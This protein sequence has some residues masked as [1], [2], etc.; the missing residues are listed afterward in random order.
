MKYVM[1]SAAEAEI[2]AL[3]LK[4]KEMVPVR[5][6]LTKI[7]WH[8]PPSP[9]QCDNSTAVRMTDSTLVPRKYKSW[10]LRLNWLQC[11]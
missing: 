4:A 2:G 7:G 9:I 11:I 6:T 3:L 8:Q 10:D 5:H 1:S